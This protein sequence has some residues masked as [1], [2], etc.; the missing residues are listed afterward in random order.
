MKKILY[1]R[2]NYWFNLKAGGSVGHTSG[3][4]NAFRKNCSIKVITND[5]LVDVLENQDIIKPVKIRFLPADINEFLYNFKII[6]LL[7]NLKYDFIY[8]RYNGFSFSSSY[9]SKKYNIP[10]I[11]EYNGS[12]LWIIKKWSNKSSL[13][14]SFF[15]QIYKYLF[16]LPVVYILENYNLNRAEFIVVVSKAMKNELVSRGIKSQKILINPNGV[17][18]NK[19]HPNIENSDIKQKY[20]LED[21]IVL[22]FIGTFGQWHGAENIALAYGRLL[23]KYPEYKEKSKLLM[24]GDGIKI[25]EVKKHIADF[26]MDTNIVLTGLIPQSEGAKYLSACDVLINS[27]VPNP[28]GSEF[29]GSPTK[30]FE[31][32]AMQKA[33]ISSNMAQMAEILEHNKTA[34]LVEPAN[35]DELMMAMKTLIDDENLRK[36]L[37]KNARAEVIEKYTWDKHV[38]RILDSLK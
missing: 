30:L 23:Q 2:T 38:K 13:L 12:D 22:G 21:K 33:I 36:E 31:Y 11:L 18:E 1:L 32:M 34:F 17:D 37:G 29:F 15:T 3:V 6:R 28:D 5:F 16:R 20:G 8:H 19:Y 25:G 35:I 26:G 7:K 24:I 14:K 9:L 10:L 27:T 4:I